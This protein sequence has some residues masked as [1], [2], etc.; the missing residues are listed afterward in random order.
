MKKLL[1]FIV[2]FGI[3]LAV[4]NPSIE[5]Y[6]AWSKNEIA[7]QASNGVTRVLGSLLGGA[8]VENSTIKEDYIIFSIYETDILDEHIRTLGI[9]K[10]F[11]PMSNTSE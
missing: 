6:K 8:L 1:L 4:T 2:I 3:A 5:D 10:K 7:K 11:V 9:L